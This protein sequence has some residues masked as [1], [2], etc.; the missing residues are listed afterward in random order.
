MVLAS[1]SGVAA[2][3][4]LLQE[5]NNTQGCAARQNCYGGHL[6]YSFWING[7]AAMRTM[8]ELMQGV[9]AAVGGGA[10]CVSVGVRQED[11]Q[12]ANIRVVLGPQRSYIPAAPDLPMVI[13][14]HKP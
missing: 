6:S 12:G 13:M 9:L 2:K 5:L 8:S 11:V 3:E 7:G 4:Q 10:T 1:Q 14:F